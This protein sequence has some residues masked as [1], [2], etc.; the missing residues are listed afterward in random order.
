MPEDTVTISRHP[1]TP[2]PSFSTASGK[3]QG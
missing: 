3:T 1:R 2:R